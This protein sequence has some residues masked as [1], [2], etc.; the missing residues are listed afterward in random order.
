MANY[1][2]A[3]KNKLEGQRDIELSD[4][5]TYLSTRV[6]VGEHPN[7]GEEIEK[8]IQKIDS[9]DSQIETINR[10]FFN[11]SSVETEEN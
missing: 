7:F 10:Y 6:A 8:K 11:K 3:I 9:L 2:L 4:L 5:E 1:L